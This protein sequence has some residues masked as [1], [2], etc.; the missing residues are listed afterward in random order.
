MKYKLGIVM[1][2]FLIGCTSDN[3]SEPT[4]VVFTFGEQSISAPINDNSVFE[5]T[6]ETEKDNLELSG[7]IQKEDSSYIVDIE[8]VSEGKAQKIR[9]SFSSSVL[10][11]VGEPLVVGRLD[12]DLFT[13]NLKN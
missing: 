3:S 9:H 8:F 12:D 5:S 11:K 2:S 1:C 13:V 6:K 10:V 7:K 4:E